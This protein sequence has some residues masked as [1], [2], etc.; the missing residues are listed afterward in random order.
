MHAGQPAPRT[1]SC[2]EA[3]NC[4]GNIQLS[5]TS[6]GPPAST[7]HRTTDAAAYSAYAAAG[8]KSSAACKLQGQKSSLDSL[9]VADTESREVCSS[10][11]L[12][13][14]LP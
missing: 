12:T 13:Q 10:Q 4:C 1:K 2:V 11:E 8:R 7:E 9:G 3:W 14:N 6:P 5:R